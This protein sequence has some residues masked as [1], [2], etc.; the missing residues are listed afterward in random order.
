MSNERIYGKQRRESYRDWV[1]AVAL[2]DAYPVA[3]QDAYRHKKNQQ[4]YTINYHAIKKSRE[5][6]EMDE[7]E[8]NSNRFNAEKSS[9]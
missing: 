7:V 2:Q 8:G 9:D 5:E 4:G 3:L 6:R 1:E